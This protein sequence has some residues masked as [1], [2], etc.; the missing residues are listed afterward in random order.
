MS[1]KC[2]P[3]S[4]RL[5]KSVSVLRH[6]KHGFYV[7]STTFMHT[8]ATPKISIDIKSGDVVQEKA[9]YVNRRRCHRRWLNCTDLAICFTW[10]Q[11]KLTSSGPI[12][13]QSGAIALNVS[14][15]STLFWILITTYHQ[16][17]RKKKYFPRCKVVIHNNKNIIPLISNDV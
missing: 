7:P 4:I 2:G 11:V 6:V 10:L 5:R 16:G 9:Q 8:L 1:V 17:E 14:V 13:I 3:K 12:L 15:M